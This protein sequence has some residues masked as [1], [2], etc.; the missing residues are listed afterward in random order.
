MSFTLNSRGACS[1]SC[2]NSD[3]EKLASHC[4][5][6]LSYLLYYDKTCV[7]GQNK[8]CHSQYQSPLIGT[9]LLRAE[10][11]L[12]S[13]VKREGRESSPSCPPTPFL[14]CVLASPSLGEETFALKAVG[15]APWPAISGTM[16]LGFVTLHVPSPCC[17]R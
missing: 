8:T 12:R 4:H 16:C 14:V 7:P 1:V 13:W 11:H 5:S 3:T 2:I 17:G 15:M 6:R 10:S 9:I